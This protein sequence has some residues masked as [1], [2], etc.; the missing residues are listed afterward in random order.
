MEYYSV[1]K[2]NVI[3]SHE[4]TWKKLKCILLSE[5]NQSEKDCMISTIQHSEKKQNYRDSKKI[6]GCRGLVRS[7]ERDE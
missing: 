3:S 7:K 5:K 4:M 6:R 1:I 2:R